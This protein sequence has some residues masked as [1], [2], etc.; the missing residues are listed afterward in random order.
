MLKP[1]TIK[2]QQKLAEYVRSGEAV[3][4][5][6]APPGRLKHYRR[7][8]FNVVNNTLLQAYPIASGLLSE[9]EWEELVNSFFKNNDCQTPQ[10]W[11]LPFE[12]YEYIRDHEFAEKFGKEYLSDL[13]LFE[14]I[15]IEVHAMPDIESGYFQ[16]EG[17]VL[18]NKIVLNP[19]HRIISLEYPIHILPAR[20]AMNK[21]GQYFLLIFREPETGNVRFINLSPVYTSLLSRIMLEK[22]PVNKYLEQMSR[23]FGIDDKKLFETKI[24][25]FLEELQE[26][27]MILGFE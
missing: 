6:G 5:S 24:R 7:L 12:F 16:E 4:L 18:F 19:E 25:S 9:E 8:V 17:N 3:S 2:T 1:D 15:E 22:A 27:K 10:V 20:E 14:W 21:K 26:Q 23:Q 11:K 13:L